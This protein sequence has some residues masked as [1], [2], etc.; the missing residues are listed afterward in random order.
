[1]TS[2]TRT[3]RRYDHRL[4]KLVCK[5]KNVDVAVR[6]GVRRS[7]ARGWLAP[8]PT[9]VVTLHA[10]NQDAFRLQ[11]EVIALRRRADGLVALLRL[12]V[13]LLKLSGSSLCRVQI[14]E[15]ASILRLL[16]TIVRARAHFSLRA[17]LCIIGL[18]QARYHAWKDEPVCGL[19]DRPCCPRR[20]PQQLTFDEVNAIHDMVTSDQ[21]WHVPTDR[22]ACLAQRLRKAFASP[23]MWRRLVRIHRWRRPRQRVHPAK[24]KVGIRASRPNEIWHVDTTLIRWLDG[25]RV[26]VRAVIDNFSRRVLAWNVRGSFLLELTA[27]LLRDAVRNSPRPACPP[28]WPKA[29][30]RTS[31]PTL[32]NSCSR[33]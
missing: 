10:L 9:A 31:I 26:Y 24:P 5:A 11:Q 30:V 17:V 19:I 6:H 14:L 20:S 1:M 18:S 32:T 8:M 13:L 7:T 27:T 33:A 4:R 25:S 12:M 2:T 16:Q 22:L 15:G 3:Q 29:A 28:L 21:Y 23:S